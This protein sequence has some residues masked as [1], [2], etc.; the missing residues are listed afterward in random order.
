MALNHSTKASLQNS[1]S[2]GASQKIMSKAPVLPQ[3][4]M[5]EK[6]VKNRYAFRTGGR[7][8]LFNKTNRTRNH[9]VMNYL[10]Q[11]GS[12]KTELNKVLGPVLEVKVGAKGQKTMSKNK[13]VKQLMAT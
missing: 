13:T 10:P 2:K 12:M 6:V 8:S 4:S 1:V 7:G 11:S 9:N 5:D 3:Y